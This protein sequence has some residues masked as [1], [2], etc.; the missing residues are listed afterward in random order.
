VSPARKKSKHRRLKVGAQIDL[1]LSAF[2]DAAVEVGVMRGPDGKPTFVYERGVIVVRDERR[3]EVEA[4]IG[5][6]VSDGAIDGVSAWDIPLEVHEPGEPGGPERTEVTIALD[7]IDRMLGTGVAT[8]NHILS[9]GSV[10]SSGHEPQEVPPG[11]LPDPDVRRTGGAGAFIYL[12]DVGLLEDG[13]A[14]PWLAGVRGAEDRLPP[15]VAGETAEIPPYGGHG[16]F[17]AGLMRC[18]APQ[19]DVFVSR[20]FGRAGA[21]SEW[22]LVL[23]LERAL[24]EWNPDVVCLPGGTQTRKDRPLLTFEAFWERRL[25]NRSVA[26]VAAAGD[27]GSRT[28]CWPARCDWVIGVGAL[29]HAMRGRASFSSYG[30]GINVYTAGADLVNA[31]STGTYTCRVRPHKGEVRR[32]TGLA[33]WSGTSFAAS[34]AA[35]LIAARISKSGENGRQAAGS[36]LTAA[37][38]QKIPA[39][40]PVLHI[41]E[42]A[43]FISYRREDSAYAA[44]WL[45]DRLAEHFDEDHI[46][47]DVDAIQVGEDFTTVIN[48][49]VASCDALVALIGSRWLTIADEKGQ[50]RLDNPRDYVRLEIEAALKRGVPIIAALVDGAQ[51]PPARQLP[52]S[53]ARLFDRQAVELRAHRFHSDTDL[54]RK[55]VG[56]AFAE[57]RTSSRG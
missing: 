42:S 49:K 24:D 44:G 19:A 13:T 43:V 35:G 9:I 46:F 33:R 31:F 3:R 20:V 17:A 32:F 2:K 30:D 55:A 8:P 36:L 14:H 54:L 4:L 23:D 1:I 57:R 29:D 5:G 22:N 26:L 53:L 40:G 6:Q 39:V 21:V 52:P 34:A 56:V 7:R 38:A 41:A 50:R 27:G 15:P 28:A 48:A 25:R 16:T 10:W 18:M 37:Q 51:V 11:V 47:K 12:A 45:Y